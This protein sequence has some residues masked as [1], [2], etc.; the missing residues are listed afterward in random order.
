VIRQLELPVLERIEINDYLLYPGND[1]TGLDIEIPSGIS[2]VV[3]INGLGKTTL[4]NAIL[5]GILGPLE[6]PKKTIRDLGRSAKRELL[7]PKKSA[8]FAERVSDHAKN[9]TLTVTYRL[10]GQHVTVKRALSNLRLIDFKIGKRTFS[11]KDEQRYMAEVA[12]L[13]GVSDAYE[14]HILVRFIQ[15]FLEDRPPI[16][17]N[18]GIQF[19]IFRV[20]VVDPKVA[21]K[22]ANTFSELQ[23]L[24]THI[25]NTEWLFNKQVEELKQIPLPEK[26]EDIQTEL[27]NAHIAEQAAIEAQDGA[28]RVYDR[29]RDKQRSLEGNV[30]RKSIEIDKLAENVSSL[31]YDYLE[32]RFPD[33]TD[34]ARY[35]FHT[36]TIEQTC[37]ICGTEGPAP[38]ARVIEK[39]KGHHCPLCDSMIASHEKVIPLTAKTIREQTRE[40]DQERHVYEQWL[41]DL[42]TV[43]ADIVEATKS[44]RK[45]NTDVMTSRALVQDLEAQLPDSPS[46]GAELRAQTDRTRIA[47]EVDKVERTKLAERYRNLVKDAKGYVEAIEKKLHQRFVHYAKAFLKEK[48]DLVLDSRK[49]LLVTGS[50]RIN[51]PSFRVEMASPANPDLVHRDTIDSVSESQK[52]FLDLAFRMAIMDVAAPKQHDAMLVIET[53]EASLDAIFIQRAAQ[54]LREFAAAN[55]TQPKRTVLA[56]S[57]LTGAKMI[58]ALLGLVGPRDRLPRKDRNRVINLLDYAAQPASYK[59]QQHAFKRVLQEA[60][61]ERKTTAR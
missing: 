46:K 50:S 34:S 17:W 10:A 20:L 54:M 26:V 35:L 18:P 22:L 28:Q 49:V 55:T 40:L 24:D 43:S 60:L 21:R 7:L 11:E 14:F 61:H 25:R 30:F 31:N 3:G 39:A 47:L 19:E 53:P 36:V 41:Q 27:D 5:R 37:L 42:T 56:S 45:T 12:E 51:I 9:A 2:V 52:E 48:V 15:F 23:S 8:Y 4:L 16:L 1:G 44:L 58:S 57:N 6:L 59:E 13:A 32:Q 29:L 33:L 38:L